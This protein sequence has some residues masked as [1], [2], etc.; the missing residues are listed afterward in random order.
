MD[1]D[2]IEQLDRHDRALEAGDLSSL[3]HLL[4][5]DFIQITPAAV[6]KIKSEWFAWFTGIVKYDRMRR[7]IVGSRSFADTCIVL[8]ECSPVM[9]V[10]GG[11]PSVHTAFMLEVWT[12]RDGDWRKAVEQYTKPPARSD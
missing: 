9:R 6:V 3:D 8:S 10:K 2:L 7:Q 5:E 11:E 12:N 4:I 1:A